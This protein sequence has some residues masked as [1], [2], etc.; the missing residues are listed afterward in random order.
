M[1]TP[2]RERGFSLVEMMV[3]LALGLFIVGGA[4]AIFLGT[5]QASRTTDNMS[6]LQESARFAFELMSREF[7]EAGNTPCG[8]WL[9]ITSIVPGTDWWATWTQGAQGYGGSTEF[10]GVAFGSTTGARV[11]GTDAVEL[12]S[13]QGGIE[14][15]AERGGS[16]ELKLKS[17]GASELKAGDIAL[18]CDYR[19]GQIF[20]V[21][22]NSG[23]ALNT[24][25]DMGEG[26]YFLAS[27]RVTRLSATAW[28]IGRTGRPET[29][30]LGLFRTTPAGAQEVIDGVR[31]MQID[32]L[33]GGNYVDASLVTDWSQVNAA[34]ITLTFQSPERNTATNNVGG[35]AESRIT[36]TFTHTVALRNTML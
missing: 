7:R 29:G 28:Y 16:T 33:F 18:A 3:A 15:V 5:R 10:P 14:A 4:V 1:N 35:V 6:R 27:S 23:S 20:K 32:F 25:G 11:A 19:K 12:R 34:R 8:S 30:G 26:N 21:A 17:S 36:R 13:T 24:G 22:D 31:D 2:R 9:A